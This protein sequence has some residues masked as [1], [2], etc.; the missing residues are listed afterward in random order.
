M[1]PDSDVVNRSG[2]CASF[3]VAGNLEQNLYSRRNKLLRIIQSN[4]YVSPLVSKRK[5]LLLSAE[6]AVLSRLNVELIPEGKDFCRKISITKVWALSPESVTA[7]CSWV[8][9]DSD[10]T[11]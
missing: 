4:N 6:T 2:D 3:H 11:L 9:A 10:A 7:L 8:S 5:D 1:L